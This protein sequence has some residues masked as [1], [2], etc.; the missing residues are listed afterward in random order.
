MTRILSVLG[1]SERDVSLVF[2]GNRAIRSLNRDFR[3]KDCPTD[4][5]SFPADEG[6]DMGNRACE[7]GDIVISAE[8]ANEQCAEFGTTYEEEL[9]R[10]M[11]HGLLHL[12]GHDHQRADDTRRMKAAEKRLCALLA[13][14][15]D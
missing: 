9:E 15:P 3:A 4:V 11:V 13:K 2:V 10:L 1:C 5:L 8:R 12:L 7:L 14:A 6:Q